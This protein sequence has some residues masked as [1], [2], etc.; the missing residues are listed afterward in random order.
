MIDRVKVC[1]NCMSSGK[2][3]S[4]GQ[5]I[6]VLSPSLTILHMN[7]QAIKLAGM[8]GPAEPRG[9]DLNHPAP[10][11]PPPL[12]NLAGKFLSVLRSRHA[13]SK[14]GLCAARHSDDGFGKLVI[15]RGVGVPSVNGLQDSRIVLLLTETCANHSEHHQSPGRVQ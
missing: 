8:L 4:V 11:L 9:R 6:V 10:V 2:V 15:V 5:G 1:Q 7:H 14:K 3:L 12:N 13:L